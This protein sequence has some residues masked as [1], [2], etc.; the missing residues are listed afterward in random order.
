MMSCRNPTVRGDQETGSE[1][2]YMI[3]GH[4]PNNVNQLGEDIHEAGH[5]FWE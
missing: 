4:L 3:G 5:S 1:H 2:L